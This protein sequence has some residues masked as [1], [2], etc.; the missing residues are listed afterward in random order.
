MINKSGLSRSSSAGVVGGTSLGGALAILLV[1]MLEQWLSEPLPSEIASA[2]SAV[3]V[4][5]VG[6]L[7]AYF[8]SDNGRSSGGML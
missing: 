4:G 3:V 7:S 5:I 8:T 2:I 6:A 1:W